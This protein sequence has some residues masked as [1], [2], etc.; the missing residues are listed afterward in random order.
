MF[1]ETFSDSELSVEPIKAPSRK[2]KPA[3]RSGTSAAKK[4]KVT[5]SSSSSSS[6][7]VL[8]KRS[9]VLASSVL[10][11]GVE[12]YKDAENEED[13]AEA[14]VKLAQYTKQL[15]TA[16]ALSKSFEGGAPAAKTKAEL[17]AAAENIKKVAVSGITK[18]MKVRVAFFFLK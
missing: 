3:A 12:F 15:E 13:A 18:Q 9:S 16:L 4:A 10:A 6:V 7:G 8:N 14:V 1:E 2:R 17:E 11:N 5:A